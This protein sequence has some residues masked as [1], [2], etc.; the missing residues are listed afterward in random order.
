MDVNDVADAY[1]IL[2]RALQQV[3]FVNLL[4]IYEYKRNKQG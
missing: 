1:F 4:E 3:S 2:S